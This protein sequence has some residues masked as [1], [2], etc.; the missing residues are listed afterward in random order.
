MIPSRKVVIVSS[1]RRRIRLLG[2]YVRLLL[3]RI[4]TSPVL[5]EKKDKERISR[6]ERERKR[7]RLHTE[8]MQIGK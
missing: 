1:R 3:D 4:G 7:A 8:Y 5:D 2:E 6:M